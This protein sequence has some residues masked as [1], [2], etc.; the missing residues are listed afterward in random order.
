MSATMSGPMCV[1]PLFLGSEIY[2]HSSYGPKHPLAIPRVSTAIDLCRAMG[3][4]PQD[5]YADSPVASADD[6]ARYHDAAYIEALQHAERDQQIDAERRARH[7]IG[8]VENPIFAEIFSRPATAAGASLLAA[9]RLVATPGV[10]FSPAGG[11]H[12]G[13]PDRASGFCYVNDP[14]LAILR[15][16]D[17][18]IERIAY[19]DVDAHHGDGVQDAFSNDDRVLTLS[20]H[21]E[22]RWPFTGTVDDRAGGLA[23][24]LPLPRGF[25]DDEMALVL[26]VMLVPLVSGFDPQVV[27]LQCGADA[28]EDDPL[29]RL[30][31]S[32]NALWNV[33][34]ALRPLAPRFMVL[35]GGGYNPWT[36]GRC[37]AGIW[38][39]LNDIP[40]PGPQETPAAAAA[41]LSGLSWSR[42]RGRDP[43]RAWLS[44]IADRPRPG[45][46]RET[47]RDR[48]GIVMKP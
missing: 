5:Q 34:R 37:W 41:V 33:V 29:S 27:V 23:R 40:V 42:S 47:I 18:G 39:I 3:W 2:R 48:L 11:T 44:T 13:R 32:N 16:L 12:H 7:N 9:D 17:R 36:V 38:A 19:V 46:I 30:S 14:V 21:E 6:L 22:K 28:L 20:V 26:D 25:N 10:V 35:G 43:E 31:L 8:G 15:F 4:L 45:P 24:N 1:S